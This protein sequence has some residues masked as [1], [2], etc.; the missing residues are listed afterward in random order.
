MIDSAQIKAARA[1]LGI[2]QMDLS[3]M[4]SLSIATVK[5]IEAAPNVRGAAETFLKI[6]TALERAGV[7]FIQA[8]QTGGPGVRLRQVPIRKDKLKAR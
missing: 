7:A 1:L 3:K 5:R 8:D 6:Q 2:N 4:A